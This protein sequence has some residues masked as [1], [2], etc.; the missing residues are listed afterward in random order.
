MKSVRGF[1]LFPL[2]ILL[3][4]TVPPAT[5]SAPAVPWQNW[6]IQ[7]GTAITSPPNTYPSFVGALQIQGTQ[8]SGVFTP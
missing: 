8:A 1:A 2:A 5:P 3:G 6:Q 7:A 4:C